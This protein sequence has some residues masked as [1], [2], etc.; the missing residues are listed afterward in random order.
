MFIYKQIRQEKNL[1]LLKRNIIFNDDFKRVQIHLFEKDNNTGEEYETLATLRTRSLNQ[2]VE[3]M[4]NLGYKNISFYTG[5]SSNQ[6]TIEDIIKGRP[7][8]ILAYK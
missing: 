3:V 5:F 2:W 6:Y 8:K 1:S 4:E 7:V